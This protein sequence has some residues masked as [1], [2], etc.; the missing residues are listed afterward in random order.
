MPVDYSTSNQYF[1]LFLCT[2]RLLFFSPKILLSKLTLSLEDSGRQVYTREKSHSSN[3]FCSWKDITKPTDQGGLGIRDM[4]LI[5]KSLII[6]SAWN[7]V[8]NKK[9]YP[10]SHP[11]SQ[12]FPTT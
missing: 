12:I 7:I 11:Q 10:H 1:P 5:N 3:Y 4:E 8:T 6:N 9:P 2:T